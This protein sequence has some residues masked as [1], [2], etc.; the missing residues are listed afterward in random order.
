VKR[1]HWFGFWRVVEFLTIAPNILPW[2]TIGPKSLLSEKASMV[3]FFAN[4]G[5][6][7]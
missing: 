7:G 2:L 5:L 1:L 4:G 3:R 6:S